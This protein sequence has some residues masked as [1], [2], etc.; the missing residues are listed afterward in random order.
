MLENDHDLFRGE[1]RR[2]LLVLGGL[3]GLSVAALAGRL[4]H[5]QVLKGGTYHDLAEN[6]RISLEPIAAPRGRI[7]DRTGGVL[8]DNT[9]EYRLSVIPEL[10]GGLGR[11]LR[12]LAPY[13]DL[14]EEEILS[15]IKK[16]RSQRRFLPLKVKSRLTWE[17][18]S[19]VQVRIHSFPGTEIQ[20]YNLRS[21]P[22]GTLASHVLGYLGEVSSSDKNA[23]PTINFRS[24]DLVGKAGM[25]RQF[26]PLLRGGEGVREME[27]NAL[28]RQVRELNRTD[29]R[30]GMD[31]RLTIDPELQ[32]EAEAALGD[33]V[34]AVVAMD[35]KTGAVLAMASQPSFDPNMFIQGISRKE[36]NAL[37]TD[38]RRPLT[39]K[40][41]QGQY[42][43]GSTFKMVVA[44]A[45][46]DDGKLNPS[47]GIYCNGSLNRQN[48]RFYCWQH[49]GH[50]RMDLKQAISQSCDVYF[51]KMA[52]RI[53]IDSI[54]RHAHLLG[55][56]KLTGLGLRE[57]AAGLIP[58]RAWKRRRFNA[59]WFPG[60]T[61]ITAI[62]QGYVLATP[63]QLANMI[64][65]I[66]NGGTLRRPTLVW[67]D[68]GGQTEIVEHGQINRHHLS[69]IREGLEEVVHG[70]RGTGRKARSEFGRVAGKTGTSQVVRG[71]RAADGK[72]LN[73]SNPLY[74]DHALFV[75]FAPVDDPAIAI[76]VIVENGGHG[77]STAAPVAKRVIDLYLSRL[78]G[79]VKVAGTTNPD[80]GNTTKRR[81]PPQEEQEE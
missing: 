2:R 60:E 43:P 72:A 37:L 64:A 71:K 67:N 27:V 59:G 61:L 48:H 21:Y 1:S 58:S 8:V 66:A 74:Q 13:V 51:Y 56:G 41:I 81:A 69:L 23:F 30:P 50:G 53:G 31:L 11:L 25:E 38:K 36:W 49:R 62:G 68:K 47:E 35:P 45:A 18:L 12:R 3:T 33:R 57:E 54:E 79:G 4:F 14:S 17:E 78:S 42:P 28:G 70:A 6:N 20:T 24:G 19:R 26:E 5:L 73:A 52:E 34:G 7:L 76:S 29:P 39:N 15:V 10:S 77:G 63:L 9:P 46:L 44:L 80:P 32:R 22:N 16:S 75:A 55:L 65:T 40:A